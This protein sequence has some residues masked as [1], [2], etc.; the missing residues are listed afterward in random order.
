MDVRSLR[1]FVAVAETLHFGHAAERLGM[2]QPPLSQSIR[3]LER[4]LGAPL[5]ARTRRSVAL[6]PFGAQWLRPVRA[7]LA[8]VDGLA[9]IARSLR[10]GEAGRLELSFVSTADYSILPALVR[11]YA[12][13]CPGV[14]IALHEATSDVQMAALRSGRGHAG[15]I[16]A[17]GEGGLPEGLHYRRVLTEPLVAALPESWIEEKRVRLQAG[18]I[19]AA[20]VAQAPLIIFPRHLAPAF[21]DLVTSYH[22][23]LGGAAHVVQEAIQMQTIIGLVS[24]GMG[25]SLVPASL[26][27]LARPGVRYVDLLGAVPTLETGIVWRADDSTATLRRFLEVVDAIVPKA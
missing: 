9:A 22:S 12:E 17:P 7:A 16:I 19:D 25:V 2:T 3:A 21:H 26:R 14:E 18:R 10:D 23:D 13:L 24:A 4:E 11:R 1:H 6:T 5:F 15:I 27:N 20:A 8:G